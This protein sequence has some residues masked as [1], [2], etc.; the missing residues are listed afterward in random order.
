VFEKALQS[1][2]LR[3]ENLVDA[4]GNL[5]LSANN[6]PEAGLACLKK[7]ALLCP[8]DLRLGC[9]SGE[10]AL[11]ASDPEAAIWPS[12]FKKQECGTKASF[13]ILKQLMAGR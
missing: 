5:S 8:H 13:R 9:L 12:N 11:E 3:A 4:G 6:W 10:L 1:S 7:A 2:P